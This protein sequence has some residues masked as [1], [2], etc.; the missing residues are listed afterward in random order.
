MQL[1]LDRIIMKINKYLCN[2]QD[3]VDKKKK[4]IT[5]KNIEYKN[6]KNKLTLAESSTNI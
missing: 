4:K 2:E 3:S 1:F 6:R 5:F